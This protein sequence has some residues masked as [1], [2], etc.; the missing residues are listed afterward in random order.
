[1]AN[2]S[3]MNMKNKVQKGIKLHQVIARG[4]KPS[5]FKSINKKGK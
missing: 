1:M 3:K 5:E 2:K 4:G